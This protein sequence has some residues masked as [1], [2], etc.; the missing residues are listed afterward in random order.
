[1]VRISRASSALYGSGGVFRLAGEAAPF[2][3]GLQVY[4]HRHNILGDSA[5]RNLIAL[6][7]WLVLIAQTR[8]WLS[9]CWSR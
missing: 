1:M 4:R 3:M 8:A 7:F 9:L 6:A 2:R 5:L